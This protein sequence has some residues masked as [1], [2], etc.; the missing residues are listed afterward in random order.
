VNLHELSHVKTFK[1]VKIK[2]FSEYHNYLNIFDWAMI[3]QLSSHHIYD[4]KIKLINEKTFLQSKL[5]QMFDHKLQKIKKYLIKHLNKEFIFFSF[6]SELRSMKVRVLQRIKN[7]HK[8]YFFNAI[9]KFSDKHENW[10]IES[11]R[12]STIDF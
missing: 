7:R 5:Y 8:N 9:I 11:T 12:N 6:V 2:L 3:D 10:D 1:Q 4:H